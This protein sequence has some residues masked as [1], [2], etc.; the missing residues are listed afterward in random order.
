MHVM[1]VKNLDKTVVVFLYLWRIV[2][3][4]NQSLGMEMIVIYCEKAFR[5]VRIFEKF[6]VFEAY[7]K[8]ALVN[9][10]KHCL[11]RI[12]PMVQVQH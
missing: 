6:P 8:E 12:F 2:T 7:L 9:V 10:R 5:K 11:R 4:Y 1:K 3:P